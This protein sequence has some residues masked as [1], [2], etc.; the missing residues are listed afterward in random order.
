MNTKQLIETK[1]KINRQ[2]NEHYQRIDQLKKE[3]HKIEC[4]LYKTCN[5]DWIIDRYVISEHTEYECSKCGL[6][7][8]PYCYV[9]N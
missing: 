5:H 2:I 3:L 9:N 7:R 1:H 6:G 4:D 8:H